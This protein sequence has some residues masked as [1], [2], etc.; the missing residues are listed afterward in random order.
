[1]L[2]LTTMCGEYEA[3]YL[4]GKLVEQGSS[5]LG[6]GEHVMYLPKKSK[7]LNFPIEDITFEELNEADDEL[8]SLSG[9]FPDNLSSF[10]GK[11]F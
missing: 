9:L 3:L 11:Y 2:I 10:S 5:P 8:V 1:M 4:H 7:E 6:E